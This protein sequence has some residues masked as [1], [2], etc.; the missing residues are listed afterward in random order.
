MDAVKEY[1]APSELLADDTSISFSMAQ[2]AGLVAWVWLFHNAR[3]YEEISRYLYGNF[4]LC[5]RMH[6]TN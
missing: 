2:D 1:A 6:K 5:N 4:E 3:N